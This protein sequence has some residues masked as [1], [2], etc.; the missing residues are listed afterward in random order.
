MIADSGG[1][2]TSH[3]SHAIDDEMHRG[4]ERVL[5]SVHLGRGRKKPRLVMEKWL[6][7]LTSFLSF[8]FSPFFFCLFLSFFPFHYFLFSH[9]LSFPRPSPQ[10]MY[11]FGRFPLGWGGV[12]RRMGVWR[13]LVAPV[14]CSLLQVRDTFKGSVTT[15]ISPHQPNSFSAITH[16]ELVLVP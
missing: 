14:E 13:R 7:F 5:Y 10:D 8:S 15:T 9:V 11:C 1:W 2:S 12:R 16:G 3:D 4:G 6:C